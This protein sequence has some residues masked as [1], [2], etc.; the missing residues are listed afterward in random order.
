MA[1]K[2][3][4]VKILEKI[5][6]SSAVILIAAGCVIAYQV[7]AGY[8]KGQEEYEQLR[9]AYTNAMHSEDRQARSSALQDQIETK[10]EHG[11]AEE[12]TEINKMPED[13]PDPVSVDWEG[14]QAL[15]PDTVA[16]LQIPALGLS[17]PVMQGED[18]EYYLHR[19]MQK[20]YLYAGS[21]F[22]DCQNSRSFDNYNTILY[23]HNMR[24]G[25]MFASLKK[26]ADPSVYDSCPYL[27]ICT[28]QTRLL[29]RIFAVRSA[30][31]NS[32]TYT[33]RFADQAAHQE[34]L[35]QMENNTGIASDRKLQDDDRIITLSTCTGS[36]TIR[37]V[38]QGVLVWQGE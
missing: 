2:G 33:I 6:A 27:W 30:E 3:T 1:Q 16:W 13:A 34:W 38:V 10:D 5:I 12:Q 21:I 35:R 4:K 7:N 17:Y 37:Q 15:N 28:P 9:N 18:N 20:E 23:G 14:I 26:F 11:R 8:E 36:S 32:N 22:L 24:D 25:S 29:Y 19:S 31:I